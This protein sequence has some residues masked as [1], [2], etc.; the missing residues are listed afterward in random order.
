MV[1]RICLLFQAAVL[2]AQTAINRALLNEHPVGP[3][4]LNPTEAAK[5]SHVL[6]SL[7]EGGV[8]RALAVGVGM[9]V[10]QQVS[11]PFFIWNLRYSRDSTCI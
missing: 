8:R 11:L 10:L 4:T 1:L 6:S 2:V 9:Q 3:A 7:M 5:H